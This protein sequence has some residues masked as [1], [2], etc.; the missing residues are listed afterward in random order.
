MRAILLSSIIK[1]K[2]TGRTQT[3]EGDH[4]G[5]RIEGDHVPLTEAER[6]HIDDPFASFREWWSEV[7]RRVFGDL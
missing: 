6:E 7:D 1:K 5:Q 4:L 2:I 3:S